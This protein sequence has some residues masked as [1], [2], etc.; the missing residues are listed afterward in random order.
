MSVPFPQFRERSNQ[1]TFPAGVPRA[2][3]WEMAPIHNYIEEAAV[4]DADATAAMGQAFA[5][6]CSALQVSPEDTRGREIIAIRVL[7]LARSGVVDAAALRDRVLQESRAG[8][9]IVDVRLPRWNWN[10]AIWQH[11]KS[12]RVIIW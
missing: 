2:R 10:I 4:F 8:Y 1:H 11:D 6:I 7:D 3:G 5:D 9:S 12:Y